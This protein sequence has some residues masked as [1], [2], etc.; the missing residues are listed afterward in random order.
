MVMTSSIVI[1]MVVQLRSKAGLMLTGI[2]MR[3]VDA[4]TREELPHDGVA[5]GDLQGKGRWEKSKIE[6]R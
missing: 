1:L 5:V 6:S 3:I 4:E 2:D